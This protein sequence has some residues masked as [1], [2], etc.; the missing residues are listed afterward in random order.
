MPGQPKHANDPSNPVSVPDPETSDRGPGS[1]SEES[2]IDMCVSLE[3]GESD[4]EEFT[5]D[6]KNPL[7][8]MAILAK[9]REP[10]G[11]R[12][13]LWPV[14]TTLKVRFLDGPAS[15]HEKIMTYARIW[16]T[17]ANIHFQ[18]V[19]KGFA[20]IRISLKEKKRWF[21]RV[22]TSA[23][24][25]KNQSIRTMNLGVTSETDDEDLKRHVLHEFGHAL[26]C[27]HEHS[28]PVANIP[29]NKEEVYK[30]YSKWSKEK[31][32][33]NIFEQPPS[34]LY[35]EFDKYSIMI[36]TVPANLTDGKF[37]CGYNTELSEMD[38]RYIGEVYPKQV[39]EHVYDESD[40]PDLYT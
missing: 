33:S 38:K 14:G 19:K 9:P 10:K 26:G 20:E 1:E 29:W 39:A 37:S 6:K 30:H 32:D 25:L 24:S 27:I 15:V 23:L 13:Y 40:S 3:G 7:T 21:S 36:Y 17:Y 5:N 31:V 8:I 28:S 11:G 35:S 34:T 12:G 2:D 16:E 22:G 4:D 18:V